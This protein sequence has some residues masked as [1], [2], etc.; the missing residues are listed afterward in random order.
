MMSTHF[1]GAPRPLPPAARGPVLTRWEIPHRR[2]AAQ[3]DVAILSMENLL[4]PARWRGR[5][6]F[7]RCG[8]ASR[9]RPAGFGCDSRSGVRAASARKLLA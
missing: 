4:R 3:R 9:R 6:P 1:R 2:E 7:D 8:I 5:A